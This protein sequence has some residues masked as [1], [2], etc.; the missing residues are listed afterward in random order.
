MKSWK[1]IGLTLGCRSNGARRS[2]LAEVP[3]RVDRGP[4]IRVAED[5]LD[6]LD[7]GRPALRSNVAVAC[8]MSWNHIVQD[9]GGPHPHAAI[10][11]QQFPILMSVRVRVDPVPIRHVLTKG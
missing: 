5:A 2:P 6:V 8:R 11:M 9:A 10:R 3:V 7:R 4:R 1:V